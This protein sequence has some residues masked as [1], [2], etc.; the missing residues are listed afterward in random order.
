MTHGEVR[1]MLEQHHKI[2]PWRAV[3]Y[4]LLA[5]GGGI[6]MVDPS[7]NVAPLPASIRWVW[8]TFIILGGLVSTYGAVRDRWVWEFISLP[9]LIAGFGGLVWILGNGSGTGVLAFACFLGSIVATLGRRLY[10]LWLFSRAQ[11]HL[12]KGKGR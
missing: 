11:R 7:R 4:I 12:P 10:G 8:S 1:Q 5:W 3:A 2:R 9:L 6:L